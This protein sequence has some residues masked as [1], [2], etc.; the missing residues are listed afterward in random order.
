MPQQFRVVV[1]ISGSGS[2]LQ[3]FIDAVE[4]DELP[5]EIAAVISNQADAYGLER[6]KK[7]G[8]PA[9]VLSHRE[10]DTREKFDQELANLIDSFSP[11]LLILAGFMRILSTEFVVHFSDR[12]V[13][14]HPS[15][16]PKYPGLH[17]HKRALESA[18][19]YHGA[20]VHFVIPELDAGPVI[21]QGKLPIL[22]TDTA[23]TLQQRI[24]TIEHVIYPRAVKW[25]A[26]NR[27]SV[28]NDRV[29]LDGKTSD[30]QQV[31]IDC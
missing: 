29:L 25:I 7:A 15:L 30:L 5:V 6:A 1:L 31:T 18:D 21:I 13:N 8:I 17:T 9:R 4:R 16:L 19:D 22:A 14:I 3:A 24:H 26:E 11:D 27:I 23:E 12:I 2:N 10:F 28:Q 20:S